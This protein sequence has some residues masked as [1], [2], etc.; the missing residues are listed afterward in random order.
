MENNPPDNQVKKHGGYRPG[1]GRPTDKAKHDFDRM[2]KE[3]GAHERAERILKSTKDDDQ[4]IKLYALCLDRAYG[5]PVQSIAGID[6]QGNTVPCVVMLAPQK[7][8][9]AGGVDGN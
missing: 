6:E 8:G 5:K 9:K 4:F 3:S 2:L 1:G 7:V